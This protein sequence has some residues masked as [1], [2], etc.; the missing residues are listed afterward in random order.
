MERTLPKMWT[1]NQK[2]RGHTK[3]FVHTDESGAFD[4]PEK[5]KVTSRVENIELGKCPLCGKALQPKYA[6]GHAVLVCLE[7]N[8]VMPTHD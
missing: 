3:A 7:H 6:N 2:S 8:I 5:T 4:K 1:D